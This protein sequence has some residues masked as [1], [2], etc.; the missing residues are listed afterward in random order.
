L[1]AIEYAYDFYLSSLYLED[2]CRTVFE[3]Y[4]SQSRENVVP[5]HAALREDLECLASC[6]NA[7]DEG[8]SDC[9]AGLRRYVTMDSK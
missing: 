8:G 1:S 3:S 9:I 5:T 6:L 7:L 2:N 4:H